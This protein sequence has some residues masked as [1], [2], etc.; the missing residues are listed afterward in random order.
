MSS[1]FDNHTSAPFFFGTGSRRFSLLQARASSSEETSINTEGLFTD[2]KAKVI[3]FNL[4][5]FQGIMTS[6]ALSVPSD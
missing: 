5:L 3:V 6:F 2:L 4:T 1:F